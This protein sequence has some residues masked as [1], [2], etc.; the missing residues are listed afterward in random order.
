MAEKEFACEGCGCVVA[1]NNRL[2]EQIDMLGLKSGELLS[3]KVVDSI[4]MNLLEGGP[5]PIKKPFTDRDSKQTHEL[6]A[7]TVHAC[8]N[9]R[10]YMPVNGG[11]IT[12]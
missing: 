4:V 3:S 7:A 5:A 11:Y 9:E 10:G 12:P 8:L 1:C 6:A 2:E